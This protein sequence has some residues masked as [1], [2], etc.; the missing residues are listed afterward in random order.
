MSLSTGCRIGRFI[1]PGR[2][3]RGMRLRLRRRIS[4]LRGL[5]L[6]LRRRMFLLPG[7]HLRRRGRGSLF[8]SYRNF[9]LRF[10]G[11]GRRCRVG[12][13]WCRMGIRM[14]R[15]VDLVIHLRGAFFGRRILSSRTRIGLRIRRM[16]FSRTQLLGLRTRRIRFGMGY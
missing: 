10:G 8:L 12:M 5:P 3:R 13:S 15:E 9:L 16:L 14:G 1:R 11:V 2:R 4:L 7:L 6:R